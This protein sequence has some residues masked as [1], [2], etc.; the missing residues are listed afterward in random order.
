MRTLFLAMLLVPAP[1]A[2]LAA[3]ISISSAASHSSGRYGAEKS[4][5]VT[6]SSLGATASLDEWE[7]SATLPY[8]SVGLGGAELTVGGVVIQPDGRRDRISGFG[9]AY[10]TIG[11]SLPLGDDF[12]VEVAVQAQLKLPTGARHLSTGRVDG[13]VDVELSRQFGPVSPFVSAG[14]RFYGDSAELELENGWALSAGAT[15]THAGLTFIGSYDWTSSPIGLPVAR[16][17][18]G[19]VSGPLARNWNWTMFGSTGLSEGAAELM[20]GIG[21]SRT[22]G[23]APPLLKN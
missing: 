12:P 4:T 23:S 21:L 3:Q 5:T 9:D 20:F 18:F 15:I 16:E 17:L 10:L 22:F 8:L 6:S 2:A 7:V 19:V 1:G 14:Y 13:G 11:R